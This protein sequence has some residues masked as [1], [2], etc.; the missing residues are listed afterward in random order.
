MKKKSTIDKYN[1][2]YYN[3]YRQENDHAE[4]KKQNGCYTYA[5]FIPFGTENEMIICS[6]KDFTN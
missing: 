3:Q 4:W 1:P 2:I 6:G 5:F